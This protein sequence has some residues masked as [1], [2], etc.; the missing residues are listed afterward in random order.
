MEPVAFF[1]AD[2]KG[3]I[4]PRKN[5][6]ID[7]RVNES[8]F[9]KG[10]IKP[11]YEENSE[12]RQL[13]I[14]KEVALEIDKIEHPMGQIV[15]KNSIFTDFSIEAVSWIWADEHNGQIAIAYANPLTRTF[16]TVI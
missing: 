2:W 14:P 13:V 5:N 11:L 8:D 12:M 6:T 9:T 3:N 4:C 7:V 16:V 1:R 15:L 10:W